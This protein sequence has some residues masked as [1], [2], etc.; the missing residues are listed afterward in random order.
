MQGSNI[1]SFDSNRKYPGTMQG[2]NVQKSRYFL[3]EIDHIEANA[4]FEAIVTFSIR[5]GVNS[6][7]KFMGHN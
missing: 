5:K 3:F 4:K 7:L 1:Q 2:L 6:C